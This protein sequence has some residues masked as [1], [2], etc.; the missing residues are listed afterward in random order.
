MSE[1]YESMSL[2]EWISF[3]STDEEMRSVFLNMDRALK[4]I[5][6]HDYCIE[7]FH[8]RYIDVLNNS[9]NYIQFKRLVE[10]S[11]DSIIKKKMIQEDIFHSS[12]IQIAYY[13]KMNDLNQLNP[14]FLRENFDEI[15]QFIPSEDVP[16]YRGVIQR[17]A[18]VYFC[19]YALEKRNRYLADL[20]R[21]L[22]E[23][24]SKE[25][26]YL[27]ENV[28]ITNDSVNDIIYKQI[29]GLKDRAF[30]HSL[31]IPAIMLSLLLLFG[32]VLWVFSLF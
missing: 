5:H 21:Q 20:E 6:E 16:Y 13:L 15:A 12:L 14:D 7:V 28:S 27:K 1:K 24:S 10:L 8:P 26:V 25:K 30:I 22:G 3:H 29:N 9:D 31:L 23:E 18:S 11:S 32:V 4:Y 17:G 2:D 19:E